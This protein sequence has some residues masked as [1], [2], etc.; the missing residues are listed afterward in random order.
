[1]KETIRTILNDLENVRENL[2]SLS[3]DIWLTID[4]ND[5]EAL[6][7]WTDFKM[8]FN[9]KMNEF[10]RV[11]DDLTELVQQFAGIGAEEHEE[12][13]G[14]ADAAEHERI[15]REL[16]REYRHSLDENS[17]YKRPYGFVLTGQAFKNVSTWRR[18]YR[19]VCGI[20]AKRDPDTF[21]S[22][23]G[24]PDFQTNRGNRSFTQNPD[25][26]GHA[27]ILPGGL[28]AEAKLSANSIRDQIRKPLKTFDI[29]EE[30]I[31][32]YLRQDR[33]AS[34]KRERRDWVGFSAGDTFLMNK[35]SAE[36]LP[37]RSEFDAA[38]TC[39]Y[40]WSPILK[41]GWYAAYHRVDGTC[42]GR[43]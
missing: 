42:F 9:D 4:H 10:E 6:E 29:P 25:E 35:P 33:E 30:D 40:S 32:I 11:A 37:K 14:G 41:T 26:L 28:Y 1:M 19:L 27:L 38:Q 24:D 8:S 15:I 39:F 5:N 23:P 2:L 20:L 18:L 17:T 3:D 7:E 12:E 43:I 36:I 22:L 16:N 13:E 31:T 21:Q 34:G